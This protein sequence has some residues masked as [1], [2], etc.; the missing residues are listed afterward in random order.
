MS[1]LEKLIQQYC[2]DVVE[3]K[4]LGE[5]TIMKRGTSAR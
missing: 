4:A 3:Y 5:V 2:P 1:K